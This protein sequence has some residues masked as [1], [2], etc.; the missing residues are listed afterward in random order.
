[1][2]VNNRINANLWKIAFADGNS[3][4]IGIKN[5]ITGTTNPSAAPALYPALY[6][7]SVAGTL[8]FNPVGTVAGWQSVSGG[9]TASYTRVS[10]TATAGQT[11]LAGAYTPNQLEVFVNGV[12][13]N[14]TEYTATAGM[15]TFATALA[16]GDIIETVNYNVV[17]IGAA[18]DL[19]GGTAN[20][21]PYQTAPSETVFLSAGT[22]GQVLTAGVAGVPTWVTLIPAQTNQAGKYL[23]TNGTTTSWATLAVPTQAFVAFSSTGGV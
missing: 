5:V 7:N 4:P 17:A 23:T 15:I 13:L 3:N 12:L 6:F 19:V 9:S 21:I 18:A 2:S 16:A 1:M 14:S 22:A 8:W 20:A 10:T 11:T